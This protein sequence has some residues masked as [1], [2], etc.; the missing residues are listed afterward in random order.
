MLDKET[1]KRNFS[2][3]APDYDRHAALQQRMAAELLA[4]LPALKPHRIL[5]LGCGTGRLTRQL[6]DLFPQASVV[7]LDIAPGMIEV[8]GREG[9]PN[10]HFMVGDGEEVTGVEEWDL[11]VSN[12]TLQWLNAEQVL[13][14]AARALKARGLLAFTTFGP[15]TLLELRTSGFQVNSFLSADELRQLAA[16]LFARVELTAHNVLREFPGIREL[17]YHLKELGA[18]TPV[19][20]RPADLTA[21]RRFR[22]RHPVVVATFEVINGLLFKSD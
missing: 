21:F 6:A 20:R 2:R 22:A 15:Q 9:R 4:S 10:L 12:A 8:A 13:A 18:N 5:D 11:I 3:S 16:P 19:S 1:I 7:G 17:L 14:R